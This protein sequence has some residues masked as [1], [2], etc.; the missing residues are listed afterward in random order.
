MIDG[1][2]MRFGPIGIAESARNYG[3]GGILFDIMQLEMSKRG[4]Y[5]LFFMST[6]IPGRRFYERHGVEVF[7]TFIDYRKQIV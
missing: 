4:I 6:D 2:P 1:N 3:L 5:Q 7:R